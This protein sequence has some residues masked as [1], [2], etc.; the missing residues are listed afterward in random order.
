MGIFRGGCFTASPGYSRFCHRDKPD[1]RYRSL[2]D[3]KKSRALSPS[4]DTP[5][6]RC[7]L[8]KYGVIYDLILQIILMTPAAVHPQPLT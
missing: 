8:I 3:P 4:L 1:E 5:K 6:T 2:K 7:G